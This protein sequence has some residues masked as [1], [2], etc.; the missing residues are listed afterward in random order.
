MTMDR[1]EYLTFQSNCDIVKEYAGVAVPA[2]S[3]IK[4]VALWMLLEKCSCLRPLNVTRIRVH[5]PHRYERDFV[6]EVMAGTLTNP[7]ILLGV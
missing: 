4:G 6:S 7:A 3:L 2:S 5:K 1:Y